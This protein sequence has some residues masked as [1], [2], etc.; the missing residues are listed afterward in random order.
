MA[1]SKPAKSELQRVSGRIHFFNVI[2]SSQYSNIKAV[3]YDSFPIPVRP[4][5]STTFGWWNRKWLSAAEGATMRI[6]SKDYDYTLAA[7][8]L[9]TLSSPHGE[10]GPIVRTAEVKHISKISPEIVFSRGAMESP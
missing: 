2:R 4:S 9:G 3:G 8:F 7:P 5:R 10:K 6:P 1:L